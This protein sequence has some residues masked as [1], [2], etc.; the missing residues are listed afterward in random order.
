MVLAAAVPVRASA[1]EA[2]LLLRSLFRFRIAGQAAA[3]AAELG[4]RSGGDAAGQT[5][6]A[7]EVWGGRA[8]D[9]IREELETALGG[10]ARDAFGGFVAAFTSAEQSADAAYLA[11]LAGKLG[12]K[13]APTD[14]DALRQALV[15]DALRVDIA[16]AGRFLGEVQTWIEVRTRTPNAPSLRDWLDRAVPAS[17]PAPAAA[18]VTTTRKA[19]RPLNPLRDA[20]ASAGEYRAP[21]VETGSALDAFGSTRSARR[22][23][24][25]EEAQAGMQQVAEERRTAEEEQAAKKTAAAQAEAEAVKKHAEKLAAAETDALDQRKNSWSGRMKQIVTSTIGAVGGAFLGG[26]GSRAGEAAAEAVFKK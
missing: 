9:A 4:V 14:Y 13:Q 12:W 15:Q 3:Q 2:D 7:A 23:K 19:F 22:E 18:G 20:E 1:N 17:V 11:G 8:N 16:A 24:A 6:A 5:S 21:E 26:V 25:L 10:R